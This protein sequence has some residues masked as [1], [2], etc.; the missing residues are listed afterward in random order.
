MTLHYGIMMDDN[1]GDIIEYIDDYELNEFYNEIEL[2]DSKDV[3]EF[4]D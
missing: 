2:K 3:I 1:W 4:I